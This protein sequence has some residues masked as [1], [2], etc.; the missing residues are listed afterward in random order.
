MNY[1]IIKSVLI[2]LFISGFSF[3]QSNGFGL[4]IIVGQPTGISAKYWISSNNA[5][6]FGLGY[7]FERNSRMSLHADYLFHARNIFNTNE[8]ISLHYGPGGRLRLVE[9]G[10]SRL[11]VRFDV[12]LTWVPRNSP[13]DVFL[14]IAPLLD[15]IPETKF[16]FNSGI[17]VRYYFH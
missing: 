6:D 3:A 1:S 2:V 15:I 11:G 4:G 14:E 5:L 16:S 17:G 10:D 9:T 12:G 7:S 8:N 13:V